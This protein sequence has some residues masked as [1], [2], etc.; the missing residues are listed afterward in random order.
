MPD[1]PN[2][3]QVT[4]L[5]IL[6]QLSRALCYETHRDKPDSRDNCPD[7]P[8]VTPDDLA[9]LLASPDPQQRKERYQRLFRH[10][11]RR[12]AVNERKTRQD[13]PP[14]VPFMVLSWL[15]SFEVIDPEEI[16]VFPDHGPR[17]DLSDAAL[18]RLSDVAQTVELVHE[19]WDWMKEP[20]EHPFLA[21]VRNCQ[22]RCKPLEVIHLHIPGTMSGPQKNG[23]DR[24]LVREP[25]VITLASLPPL[26]AIEVDGQ[27]VSTRS[28]NPPYTYCTRR[29]RN[30]QGELFPGPRT[31]NGQPIGDVILSSLASTPLTGD[32][33]NPI[34]ADLY[35]V[36]L[37]SYA[38]SCK[39]RVTR[40]QG[41][42]LLTGSDRLT[43]ANERRWWKA[44]EMARG[45]TL[46]VNPCTGEFRDLLIA[47]IDQ[48]GTAYL[49]PPVWWSGVG[50]GA[51]W[52]LSGGL[53]RPALLGGR[54]QHGLA[55]GYWGG[56]HR[57]VA[58]L[59]AFL[60]WSSTAGRGRHGRIPDVLK[61][62]QP[63][64]YGRMVFASWREVL[65]L[66]G[67]YVD[68][69]DTGDK[70]STAGKRYRG[71]VVALEQAGYVVPER[72]GCAS[73]GDTVEIVERVRKSKSHEQGLMIRATAQFCEAYLR[74][75]KRTNWER[76]PATR[77]LE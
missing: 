53:F 22:E 56:L 27:P 54:S 76:I 57:T 25:A 43:E 16:G 65:V 9:P 4:A 44:V 12:A 67:E 37:L 55:P 52:R 6:S 34:R 75:Q 36:A 11:Y 70:Y 29:P 72:G 21:L 59:E 63:G 39:A 17:E 64:K 5:E 42:K 15:F 23:P 2:P 49:A 7:H 26:E 38:L 71:R 48:D 74:G 33:R 18:L 45:I 3:N 60:T 50:E 28:P 77:L 41:V 47:S 61:P 19:L 40:A 58:G 1:H 32:E 51:A 73:A 62:V 31:L 20:P 30:Q 8:I 35:K 68:P 66:S 24:P 13:T 10:T 69:T 46:K 14:A